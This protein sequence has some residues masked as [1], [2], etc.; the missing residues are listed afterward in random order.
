MLSLS[1]IHVSFS[2]A[3]L[4]LVNFCRFLS[5]YER[6]RCTRRFLS[7]FIQRYL[8]HP[9]FCCTFCGNFWKCRKNIPIFEND[10]RRLFNSLFL[11]YTVAYDTQT[12]TNIKAVLIVQKVDLIQ[13]YC[14]MLT[15]NF[16]RNCSCLGS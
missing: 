5:C 10:L 6:E 11:I 13:Q 15:Y 4:F 16:H 1:C 7:L 8:R 12:F 2:S 9:I 14:V 3:A